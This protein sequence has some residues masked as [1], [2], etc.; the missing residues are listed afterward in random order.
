[1]Q[2]SG[3]QVYQ[4]VLAQGGSQTQAQVAA[5]LVSG[6]ESDG[7]PLELSGGIGPAQGLFQ[8]EPGTWTG[9]AGGGKNGLPSTVAAASWQQQVTGFINATGGK[10]GSNFQA[11][12][13]DLVTNAGNPNSSSNPAYGYTGGPQA[14]SK[15]ANKIAADAQSWGA[16]AP[17]AASGGGANPDLAALAAMSP[18]DQASFRSAVANPATA[19]YF[20]SLQSNTG[21]AGVA[22]YLNTLNPTDRANVTSY[23]QS[24]AN[25][26]P[27]PSATQAATD[28]GGALADVVAS[29]LQPYGLDTPTIKAW[30]AGAITSFAS[31]GMTSAEIAT[32]MGV[33][34]QEPTLSKTDPGL[35]AAQAQFQALY[36]GLSL[37]NQKGLPPMTVAQYQSYTDTAYQLAQAAGI[38]TGANGL[39]NT[40][41]IGALVGA[42]V[43]ATELADRINKG[44]QA[45]AQA[46]P[47]TLTLLQ[48]Y[49]PTIFPQ[50]VNGAA[51]TNAQLVAYY[52]N[53]NITQATLDN[54]ITA[55]QIG[56]EGVNSEFGGIPVAQAQTLQQAGVTQQTARDTFKTLAK[57]TPLEQT[58]PGVPAQGTTISQ[59]DLINYGFFGANQQELENVQ[60]ARKAPFSGGGGYATS[61]KGVVG[62]GGASTEGQ[63][64]T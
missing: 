52:L 20:Q 42:D 58:L 21:L 16:T 4:E 8:F 31:Q 36:P 17:I 55:A 7:D 27:Q 25:A 63:Q 49:Y 1:M 6:I 51:P 18:A 41:T 2:V 24:I 32:Q 28:Q 57:L 40:Q 3:G 35:A 48:Q 44:Y 50:G 19:A 59:G 56:T 45:A 60:S 13:P 33:E 10:G 64:G 61:A 53:P 23:L 30:A 12:G 38:T 54:Q 47:E 29:V 43:S 11:W 39:I 37:R 15:V 9:G 5:A 46:N 14:G 26:G 62:A 34:L 22:S